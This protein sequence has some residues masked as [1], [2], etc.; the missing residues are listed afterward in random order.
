M[1]YKNNFKKGVTGVGEVCFA[2]LLKPEEYKGT[3]TNKFSIM[4]HLSEADEKKLLDEIDAE[5]EKFKSTEEGSKHKY[6]YDYVN[7]L[8]EYNEKNYFKFKATHIVRTKTGKE[9]ELHVPIFDSS[10]QEITSKITGVGNG[11][12][13]K[14]SYE[15]HP[16][17]ITDKNYG[18]SLRL[19]GVQ[20]LDLV[21]EGSKSASSLGF[22]EEEGF[23][24]DDA[25]A[26]DVP[27]Y[28]EGNDDF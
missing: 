15:L 24:Q 13:A 1:A 12:K 22:G 9:W 10:C 26:I 23:K 2:H 25:E 11:S 16:F 28:E 8:K 27:F 18:V 4:L 5:W 19:T 6:K 14:V 20:I 17:F 3:D 7:G 21:E